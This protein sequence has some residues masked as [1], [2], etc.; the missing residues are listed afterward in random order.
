MEIL[1][2]PWSCRCLL[3]NTPH[4]NSQLNCSANCLR[5]DSSAWTMQKIQ[6]LCCCRV[7]FTA[8]LHSNHHGTGYIENTILPLLRACILRALPSN[9]HCLQSLLS[10]GSICHNIG[11]PSPH[12]DPASTYLQYQI[13]CILKTPECHSEVHGILITTSLFLWCIQFTFQLEDHLSCQQRNHS[14]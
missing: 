6:P 2:L 1:Q 7:M 13:S 12:S 11:Q 9:S 4:L 3:L 14:K 5:D 8:L 10:N